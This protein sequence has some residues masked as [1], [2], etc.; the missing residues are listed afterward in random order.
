MGIS[1]DSLC[2][3]FTFC[4]EMSV[5]L[6]AKSIAVL[7]FQ[8]YRATV[9][10]LHVRVSSQPAWLATGPAICGV[11]IVAALFS[12]PAVRAH[13]FCF[14]F[15]LLIFSNYYQLLTTFQLLVFC[16]LPFCVIAFS[17]VM[18]A[19]HL[20]ESSCSLFEEAQNSRLNTRKNTA[21]VVLGL[22]VVFLT[23]YVPYHILLTIIYFSIIRD[24]SIFEI[25]EEIFRSVTFIEIVPIVTHFLP[26]NPCL[27]PVALCCTSLAYRRRFKRYLSCCCK[28]KSTPTDFEI[29][30]RH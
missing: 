15:R 22:I 13:Y 9:I 6:T 24:S 23:S 4:H 5:G 12:V 10:P 14:E 19:R 2:V 3:F 27:N 29:K 20:L 25:T 16:V 7:S 28:A 11:W 17:Y 18:K 30:G 26:I 21:K 1:G 8:R